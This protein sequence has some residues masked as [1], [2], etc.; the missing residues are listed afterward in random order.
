MP[1]YFSRV[2]TVRVVSPSLN[3]RFTGAGPNI[4]TIVLTMFTTIKFHEHHTLGAFSLRCSPLAESEMRRISSA[5]AKIAILIQDR[6][7]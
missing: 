6:I 3:T 1:T 2:S 5:W 4:M 7:G